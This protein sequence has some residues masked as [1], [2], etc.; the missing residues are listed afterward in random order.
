M[1]ARCSRP[2]SCV[3]F[4]KHACGS[5]TPGCVCNACSC[6]CPSRG[7]LGFLQ[8]AAVHAVA[9]SSWSGPTTPLLACP[10]LLRA[11]ALPA[12]LPK[13][14]TCLW[15]S[16]LLAHTCC[17][18]LR[19]LPAVPRLAPA[20]RWPCVQ[21]VDIVRGWGNH[22]N[23][24]WATYKGGWTANT[25]HLQGWVNSKHTA[26]T[27]VR[28]Q[29]THS[30]MHWATYKGGWTANT[31]HLQGWMSSKHTGNYSRHHIKALECACM[32]TCVNMCVRLHLRVCRA[33]IAHTLKGFPVVALRQLS[34]CPSA[35]KCSCCSHC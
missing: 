3:P 24:H 15:P 17:A 21:V 10:H 4:V 7:F 34:S 26:L 6:K 12:F 25:Q 22:S 32:C 1:L 35:M 23:M 14:A 9:L 29:Q 11:L 8:K 30:N 28:E 27:R 18:L 31:Q 20:A 5:S 16:C 2:Q 19:C 33:L 13:A